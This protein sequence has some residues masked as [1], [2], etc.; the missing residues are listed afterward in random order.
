MGS[1]IRWDRQLD[2]RLLGPLEVLIDGGPVQIAGA[3]QR[4]IA[5]ILL[6][7]ANRVVLRERLIAYVWGDEPPTSAANSVQVAIHA[8]RRSLGA[9]RIETRGSGYL[10]HVDPHELDLHA[11]EALVQRARGEPAGGA[12]RT[13]RR[14][15]SLWRGP[16]LSD[17]VQIPYLATQAVRLEEMRLTALEDRVDADLMLARH[18]EL[19]GELEGHVGAHPLR[20][21]LHGQLIIALYR[22]GRQAEALEVYQRA[23][24]T[25]V[26]ELGIEPGDELARAASADN[27]TGLLGSSP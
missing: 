24:R 17:V 21:R 27:S 23:R 18:A 11:F 26:E 14:A 22:S 6:L 15:L 2:F 20:E 12:A 8:L 16:A 13:L 9:D 5:A 1:A 3:R 4:V 7:N 19:V 10:L 25:L